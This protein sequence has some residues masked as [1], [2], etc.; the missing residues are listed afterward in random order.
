MSNTRPNA[1]RLRP[2]IP[3]PARALPLLIALTAALPAQ[4]QLP[5]MPTQPL[6]PVVVTPAPVVTLDTG[7]EAAA[8]TLVANHVDVQIAGETAQV[9]TT[10]VWRNDGPVGVDAQIPRPLPGAWTTRVDFVGDGGG[11]SSGGHDAGSHSGSFGDCGGAFDAEVAQALDDAALRDEAIEAGE[12]AV[13]PHGVGV[14]RVAPGATVRV[15]TE[16]EAPLA[17]RGDHRRLVLPLLTQRHGA[18]APQFSASAAVQA[19]RPILALASATHAA[20]VSG[21]GQSQAQ[22]VVPAGRVHEGQFLAIDFTLGRAST[23][24]AADAK[25]DADTR[26][27]TPARLAAR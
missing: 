5:R 20:E 27:A 17:G 10:L 19:T 16:R 6:P 3:H 2:A 25:A 11:R 8:L 15:T 7:T 22:L 14:L 26:G 24:A 13:W 12:A 4:A 1:A 23:A 18:F 9:R 21:E